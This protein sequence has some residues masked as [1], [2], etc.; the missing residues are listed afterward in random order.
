[1]EKVKVVS[2]VNHE[3]SVNIPDLR[4]RRSWPARGSSVSIEREILD[5]MMFD[6]GFKN[7]ITAGILYI[8]DLDVKKDMGLEP[9]DAT[10]PQNIIVLSEKDKQYYWTG[11]SLVGFKDKIKK[12]SKPQLEELADYA[13]DNKIMNVEKNKVI[14][15]ACGRDVIKAVQLLEQDKED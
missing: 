1:M 3:V 13:I 9:E 15:E 14:K 6:V 2:Q 11:L 5:D 8:E 12:L 7:M 4:F 10:E